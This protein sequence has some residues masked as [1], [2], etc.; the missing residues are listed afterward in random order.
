MI[1]VIIRRGGGLFLN[2][3]SLKIPSCE[4][5]QFYVCS[6][7]RILVVLKAVQIHYQRT[8]Q[9]GLVCDLGV[10]VFEIKTVTSNSVKNET[11]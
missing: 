6:V 5:D 3:I 9:T 8:K 2:L 1:M 4:N 7:F 10:E 11:T